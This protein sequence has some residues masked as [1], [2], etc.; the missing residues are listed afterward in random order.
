MIVPMTIARALAVLTRTALTAALL[1]ACATTPPP[2]HLAI[3]NGNRIR[4]VDT[5]G[6]AVL[7]D[8]TRY[9]E[10]FHL[11][12]RD[13]GGRL[14]LADCFR[15]R[16]V[17][18]DATAGYAEL[19][20]PIAASSC[21]WDLA[22]SPDGQSL[23]A[24]VPARPSP[25]D[26]LFGH[27][28]IAGPQP[29]D[30]N[31]GLPLR[32]V[33]W[34]PGGG[35]LAVARPQGVEILGPGPGYATLQ[36][37]T[38]LIALDLT[39]TA[40]GSRLLAGTPAGFVVLD[41]AAG[42]ATV[43][44]DTA[45]AVRRVAVSPAGGWVAVVRQTSISIRRAG[46]LVEVASATSTAD[47]TDA[48]FSRDGTLLAVSEARDR[49][50]LFRA[51]A[52]PELSPVPLTGRVD[53]VAF[54]PQQ[55]AA[56]VPVLFVHGYSGGTAEAWFEAPAG[57]SVARALAA[58]P[59]LP[60]DAH[61]LDL[62]RRGSA[63][64]GQFGRGIQD[65]AQDIL[66]TIEGGAD[67]R[68]AQQV[69]LLNLPAY[70]SAGKVAIVAFSTGTLSSRYYLKN[71][72]GTRRSGAVTVSE[73]V[74]I[75]SPNHGVA[76]AILACS[77]PAEADRTLRQL[78]AGRV[79]TVLSAAAPCPCGPLSM[80]D[81]FTTNVTDETTFITDLNGH[82]LADSCGAPGPFASEAP[83]SRPG[84]AGGVL[85]VTLYAAGNG[86]LV[87]GGH[88]QAVDCLGRRLA[89]NLAPDAINV[90]MAGV[91]GPAAA[92]HA[93][94]PHHWETICMALRTVTDHQ[95]PASQAQACTGLTVPP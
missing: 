46:D 15:N 48:A 33:A 62:P 69:G 92:V 44:F 73:F 18:L 75:S 38:G 93:N 52:W 9:T 78:C 42:Y 32:A 2:N 27:L 6:G 25:P 53:A 89:R 91:P 13:D 58:N 23:A 67:S 43:S 61:Y 11:G 59:Q 55:V 31:L 34:R 76:G 3:A 51:P 80:P 49:V 28:R 87:V 68:G 60:V 88:T 64:P 30:R 10:V 14:A 39:Y 41:A 82:A 5:P 65:D 8:V 72:M 66:A 71:L 57:T 35:Q 21:P 81:T 20:A 22:Y 50:R 29:L 4:V 94:T 40:D 56:R 95:V 7:Q 19:G 79:G 24:T 54:R 74:A 45:G 17:E 77:D 85:Y 12:F 84:T 90:E 37:L 86:D 26:A 16:I 70:Q 1:N 83:R 47:L 36:T 63:F